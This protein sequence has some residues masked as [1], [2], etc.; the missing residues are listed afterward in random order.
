M[1]YEIILEEIANSRNRREKSKA[2]FS[3]L[4]LSEPVMKICT[5]HLCYL[6]VC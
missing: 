3:R 2:R 5:A 6:Y 1:M 4:L